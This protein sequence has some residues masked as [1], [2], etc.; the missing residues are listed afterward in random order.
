MEEEAMLTV[1]RIMQSKPKTV[2]PDMTLVDLERLFLSTSFTGFPVVKEGRLVGVIS[3][4]DI[5]RSLVTERSRAEQLSDFY[6]GAPTLS[7]EDPAQ[8]LEATAAQ[9]GVRLAEQRV[10]DAMSHNVV[11][12]ES[13][14]TLQRLAKLMVDGHLHRLPVVNGNRL[15]GLITSMDLVGAISEGQLREADEATDGRHLIA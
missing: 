8:S 1:E 13:S 2:S 15:V 11:S 7:T 6:C 3:R 9:V 5:V 14:E 4:S 12:V 10:E